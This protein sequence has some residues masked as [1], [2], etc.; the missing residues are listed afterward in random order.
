M[1]NLYFLNTFCDDVR[2]VL[3]LKKVVLAFLAS[4]SI[5]NQCQQPTTP[6]YES[7]VYAPNF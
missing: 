4:K 7:E 5:K 2:L 6:D 1:L 3:V